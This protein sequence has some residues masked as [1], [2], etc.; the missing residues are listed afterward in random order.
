MHRTVYCNVCIASLKR[1]EINERE[2][3]EEMR[4]EKEN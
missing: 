3:E 2:D 1:H 4:E